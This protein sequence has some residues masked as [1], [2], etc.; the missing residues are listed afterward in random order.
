M[1]KNH[2]K[3]CF[4]LFLVYSCRKDPGN[5]SPAVIACFSVGPLKPTDADSVK[6]DGSCSLN[7]QNF[8]WYV[9]GMLISSKNNVTKIL[10]L[11]FWAGQHTVSLKTIGLGRSDSIAQT[12]TIANGSIVRHRYFDSAVIVQ[13]PLEDSTGKDWD[14][15]FGDANI[16]FNFRPITTT[17]D[18]IPYTME[19]VHIDPKRP[20][21]IPFLDTASA[22]ELTPVVWTFILRYDPNFFRITGAFKPMHSWQRDLS[23]ENR[24]H[25]VFEGSLANPYKMYIY[26]H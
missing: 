21:D 3:I 4:L 2:L 14:S 22:I 24:N 7:S 6:F 5:T 18:A 11:Q 15:T 12:I 13:I 17:I 20:I 1:R 25:I 9:D 10:N 19:W 26:W 23:K 8:Y 16:T